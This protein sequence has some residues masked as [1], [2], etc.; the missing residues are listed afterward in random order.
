MKYK[1]KETGDYDEMSQI[2]KEYSE[3]LGN[4]DEFEEYRDNFNLFLNDYYEIIVE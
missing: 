2:K 3:L 4:T 1:N